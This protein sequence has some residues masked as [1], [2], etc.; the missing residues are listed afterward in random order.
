MSIT[1]VD[2]DSQVKKAIYHPVDLTFWQSAFPTQLMLD[3]AI[4]AQAYRMGPR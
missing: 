2:G 4:D 1:Y 3:E